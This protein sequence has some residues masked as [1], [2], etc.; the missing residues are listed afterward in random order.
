LINRALDKGQI[1]ALQV[2]EALATERPSLRDQATGPARS[3][4]HRPG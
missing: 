2:N 3:P 4:S 1:A